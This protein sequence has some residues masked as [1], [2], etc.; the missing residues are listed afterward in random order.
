VGVGNG[1]GLLISYTSKASIKTLSS[2]TLALNNVT[3]CPQAF[4]HLL[5]INKFCQDNNVL[6]LTHWF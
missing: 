4:V 6:F 1:T 3:Y 5:S 2:T